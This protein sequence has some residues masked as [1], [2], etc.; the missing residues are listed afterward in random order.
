MLVAP[1]NPEAVVA[2]MAQ[3]SVQLVTLTVTEKGYGL[4]RAKGGLDAGN[5]DIAA[6]LEQPRRPPL[7]TPA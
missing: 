2:A 1:E 6:D 5:P 3:S 4:D 7:G